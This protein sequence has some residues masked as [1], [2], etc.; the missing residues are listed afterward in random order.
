MK[1]KPHIVKDSKILLTILVLTIAF[2]GPVGWYTY[3]S[4]KA[5]KRE[6][7]IKTEAHAHERNKRVLHFLSVSM[8]CPEDVLK[9]NH[10]IE[11]L[12]HY[13]ELQIERDAKDD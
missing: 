12:D 4:F 7:R 10:Q 9:I 6:V 11:K 13:H 5:V 8:R 1:H 2:W 3:T